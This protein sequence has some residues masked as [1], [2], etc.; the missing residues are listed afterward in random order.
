MIKIIKDK[1]T[2][3]YYFIK[4]ELVFLN[5]KG[6]KLL[7]YFINKFFPALMIYIFRK[8]LEFIKPIVNN[9]VF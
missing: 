4:G 8:F 5:N 6:L 1:L 9:L 7:N 3:I 2:E